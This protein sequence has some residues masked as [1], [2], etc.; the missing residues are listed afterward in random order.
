MPLERASPC[1]CIH[2]TYGGSLEIRQVGLCTCIHSIDLWRVHWKFVRWG[3]VH[4]YITCIHWTYGGFTGNSSGGVVYM[5]TL[6]LWR[7]H[8]KFVRWGC[9]HVY[10]GPMEGSLEIRQ[11]GLC[12]CI[13]WTY[14]GFTGNSSGGVVYMYTLDLW[15][16]QVGLWW[17]YGGFTGNS[18][19]GV[20]YMYTL[21][22]WRVH[23]KFVR[24]GCVHVYIG[25]MEGSLEI[26]QVGLCTC[27]HWTYGGFT[28]NSSGGVVYMYTLIDLWRVHWKFVRWGCVHVY[29][30]PMEGSL[31][32]R[33]VGLC[34][35]IHWTYG[36]FT[37]NSSGGVVYMY[38]LDLWRVHWK[39]VRWGCVHVC[40]H[41]TYGGF[42]GNSSSADFKLVAAMVWLWHLEK[43]KEKSSPHC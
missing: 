14:G 27:I 11:V 24:W 31:E 2:W 41:W 1:R 36:G 4:V 21:D 34:T 7:V 42:T 8:W 12:T 3:C 20:V 28:G 32:I 5:Y 22:L 39:F 17:T 15:I 30:G 18:S 25:P 35:C 9:V 33:Q 16:R 38:T 13:H 29:I 43:E 19:G 40:T 10:I 23:W 6:D 37:G 26:R